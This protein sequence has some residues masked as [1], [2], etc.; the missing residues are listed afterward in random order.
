MKVHH[1][2]LGPITLRAADFLARGG[3]GAVYVRGDT[4]YKVF[5]DPAA[6]PSATKLAELA[7]VTDPCVVR[8]D[9]L[10]LD[11]GGA[12]VGYAMRYVPHAWPLC[13]LFTRTFRQ[14]HRVHLATR[15]RLVARLARAVSALHAAGVVAVDLNELNVLVAPT[16]D[17]PYLIDTDSFQT[18][19]CPATAV[20]DH[21]VDRHAPPG[22]FTPETDWFAFAV[23]T[24]QAL[25]GVH[26]FR[27]KHPTLSGLDAR[28]RA[29]ASV[30]DPAVRRP[31]SAEPLGDIPPRLRAWYE[32]VFELGERTPPPLDLAIDTAPPEPRPTLD[33]PM[34]VDASLDF[35]GRTYVVC[36]ANLLEVRT[37]AGVVV[38]RVVGRVHPHATRLFSGA[39]VQSL[40][41]ATFVSLFV[42]PGRCPQ[43][44][45]PA[46]DGY[47]VV[48]ACLDR[49]TLV[50]IGER[51]GHYHRITLRFAPGFTRHTVTVE[52]CI[53][54]S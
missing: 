34:R 48:D 31:G 6:C 7:A 1:P 10:L 13:R 33:L 26:P 39:A 11:A 35:A 37:H 19:S 24:F 44:R 2:G 8:P 36:G 15:V 47:R 53:S 52:P 54:L 21:I 17:G 42:A 14:Q 23:I 49:D 18:P 43:V 28:M 4:A 45:V 3:Q 9:Q 20:A 12:P 29:N 46:L 38:P 30:F 25:V 5:D 16:F 22:V 32:A 41:G 51:G 50:A 27:G 40:L